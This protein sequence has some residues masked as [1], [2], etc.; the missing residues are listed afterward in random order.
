M[1]EKKAE[2]VNLSELL[3]KKGI[4]KS[5]SE[6]RRC[7]STGRVTMDGEPVSLVTEIEVSEGTHEIKV[8]K[9]KTATIDTL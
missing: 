9:R 6:M 2:K 7:I 1:E 4:F 3:V 8:G 5:K